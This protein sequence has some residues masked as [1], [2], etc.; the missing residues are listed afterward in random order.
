MTDLWIDIE[1][2]SS[3]NL[4]KSNVYRYVEA[5]DFEV[6][7]CGWTEDGF[8]YNLAVGEKEIAQI[9]GLLDPTVTKVAHNAPFERICLSTMLG[10]DLPAETFRDTRAMAAAAGY[11]QKLETCA[12]ALQVSPKDSAGTYLINFFCRPYRG[13]R[14]L[15]EEAPEK[16]EAFKKYCVQ[17]VITL[18]EVDQNLP[19]LTQR[20]WRIMLADQRVNDRG[21]LIDVPLAMAAAEAA[22]TNLMM[23]ELEFINLTGVKNPKSGPQVLRWLES[24]GCPLPNLRAETVAAAL[25]G[26]PQDAVRRALELRQGLALTSSSKFEAALRNVCAD[27]RLRGAFWYYGAHTGRWAGRG[28]QPHNLPRL[29]FTTEDP[30]TDEKVFDEQAQLLAILDLMM[31]DGATPETL[32]KLVRPMFY[33]NGT[34][35]DYSAIEAR[36]LAWLSGEAWLLRAF[37]AGRD[38]Y[39]EAA[40]KMGPKFTRWDGKIAVLALGYQGAVQSLR[41][42]GM[43][44]N[45]AKLVRFTKQYRKTIPKTVQFW[46][47]FDRIFISGGQVGRIK[48]VKVG[49]DR[50][51]HLPSGRVIPYHDVRRYEVN[52]KMAT[53]FLDVTGRRTTT[54]GGKLTENVTQAVARDVLAE[55][56]VRLED[57]GHRVVGHVHD[58]L[59]VEGSDIEDV[60]KIA[61]K[62]PDWAQGLPLAA[63]GFTTDRYRKG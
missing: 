11:P 22:D 26:R 51:V 37:A 15:P 41:N 1:T 20:E 13:R 29:S 48:V 34:V 4:K 27:G 25:Q 55:A 59:M 31:G 17:D 36:V 44:G 19:P 10:I 49:K 53:S 7:M 9:P 46:Y 3:V 47:K 24:A 33:V 32:K 8:H 39:V 35:V 2:Y 30:I 23:D 57:A 43:D 21:I 61:V 12:K 18:F 58:E 60:T 28:A 40:A 38:P 14:R 6:L 56:L 63:A 5:D 45:D 54:Y 62:Q 42:M 50:L 16:W 52:G